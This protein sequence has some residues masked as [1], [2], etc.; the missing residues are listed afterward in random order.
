MDTTSS[1]ALFKKIV[2]PSKE[3][4]ASPK[5]KRISLREAMPDPGDLSAYFALAFTHKKKPVILSG[6]PEFMSHFKVVVEEPPDVYSFKHFYD[7][8]LRNINFVDALNDALSFYSAE[9]KI[10]MTDDII[11]LIE[12][13]TREQSN[14]EAWFEA[15]IG[16]L[17]SSIMKRICRTLACQPSL[18]LI[19]LVCYP[20]EHSF[21]TTGTDYGK[22]YESVAIDSYISI[23]SLLHTG[24]RVLKTGLRIFKR[25]PVIASSSDGRVECDCCEQVRLIEVKCPFTLAN[26]KIRENYTKFVFLKLITTENGEENLVLKTDHEFYYQIQTHLLCADE[27]KF[28]DF[29][30]YTQVD[31]LV[32]RIDPDEKVQQEIVAK[33]SEFF[34]KCILPELRC[35]IYTRDSEQTVLKEM[36]QIEAECYCNQKLAL[37]KFVM[38]NNEM[39]AI[40]KFHLKCLK[41][42]ESDIPKKWLCPE[43]HKRAS[44]NK[45]RKNYKN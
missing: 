37:E 23:Q 11:K 38:C 44:K 45:K 3:E 39:C 28:C 27:V 26:L 13:I 5:P 15:R 20:Q 31:T 41:F 36:L 19:L 10:K 35:K 33:C 25:Y 21:S 30:V 9:I 24:V 2:A 1:K 12:L 6:L 22:L 16:K 8:N 32:L 42:K 29:V 34:L 18:C 7:E 43:C 14:C 4:L 40:K 17:T